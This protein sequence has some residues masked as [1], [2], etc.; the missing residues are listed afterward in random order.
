MTFRLDLLVTAL[1]NDLLFLKFTCKVS[2]KQLPHSVLGVKI[3]SKNRTCTK[4]I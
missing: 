3:N 4:V 2:T 1:D